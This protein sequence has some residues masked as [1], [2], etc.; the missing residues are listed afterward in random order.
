M[1]DM[2]TVAGWA[3]DAGLR[4]SAVITAV[5]IASAESD[6]GPDKVGDTALQDA[7]WG[8]S[9]GLWQIRSLK[10]EKGKGTI[11]DADKL[12]D[13]MSNAKAMV[14]ISKNGTDWSPW[15]VTHPSDLIGYTRY[16]A[17]L[18]TAKVALATFDTGQPASDSSGG[19]SGGLLDP[20]AQLGG[21]IGDAVDA[22][23]R[24]IKWVTDPGTVLRL[25]YGVTGVALVLIGATMIAR[26]AVSSVVSVA[27]PVGRVAGLAKKA[28]A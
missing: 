9:I 3:R 17:A 18:A 21:V 25:V 28:M 2:F 6:L 24:L 23:V 20:V 16:M 11:R 8:P 10:A 27:T 12:K 14:S 19:S 7:T 4:G 1:P 22:P 13:P 5:A 15:S 26:P